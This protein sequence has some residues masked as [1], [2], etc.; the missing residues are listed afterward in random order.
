[1]EQKLKY[2][3]FQFNIRKHFFTVRVVEH[4]NRLSRE[5]VESLSLE[6]FKTQMDMVLGQ[7]V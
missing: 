7:L 6:M 3:K 1:N 5:I 2:R 4:W